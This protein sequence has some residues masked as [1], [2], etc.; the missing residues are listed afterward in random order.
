MFQRSMSP[1]FKGGTQSLR[2]F[3]NR[4]PRGI[5]GLKRDEVT[6]Y[7]GRLQVS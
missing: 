3:K 5:F 1:S 4:V 6:A 2:M 7:W